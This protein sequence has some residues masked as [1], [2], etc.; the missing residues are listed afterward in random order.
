MST[1]IDYSQFERDISLNYFTNLAI[2]AKSTKASGYCDVLKSNIK[3]SEPIS[4]Q[5]L[6][7]S[8]PALKL[9][10]ST[11]E[12]SINFHRLLRNMQ[13]IEIIKSQKV[14][15]NDTVFGIMEKYLIENMTAENIQD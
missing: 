7:S 1:Q 2:P 11:T 12:K 13:K 15:Y 4:W 5:N 14:N 10:K 3:V 6:L 8:F 9:P